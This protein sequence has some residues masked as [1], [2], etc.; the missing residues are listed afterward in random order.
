M[1]FQKSYI[2]YGG[3]WSTPFCRWQGS[4]AH[5]NSV[6]FAAEITTKALQERN[7]SP[8]VFN[9]LYLGI[10]VPQ[11]HTFY[12][13]PWL[14]GLIGAGTVTGSMIGQAC[15]TGARV[16]TLAG[17]DIEASA[18]AGEERVILTITTDRC[19]NGPHVYYPNPLGP[20]G[21]GDKEDWVWDNFGHDPFAKNAMIETAENVAKEA[22]ITKEEQDEM[23]LLRHRQYEDAL[24]DDSAFLR[25]YMVIPI[26]VKDARGRKILSTVEGDE[27]VF[28]TTAEGLAKLKPVLEGGTVPYGTQTYPADGTCGIIVTTREKARELSRDP[29]IEIQLLSYGEAR[30]KK[31]YMAQATVPATR[32]ALSRAGISIEDVKVIKT[33]NPFAVND[34]YFC[35]EMGVEPEAMNNY[36]S[37]LI[38]GHP[39]GPTG[40]RLIIEVIEEL[41]LAGGGHGL[42]VGCAAGDTSAAVVLK[43]TA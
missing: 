4:F 42:F 12:G 41:I 14:S 9:G 37:S 18:D 34:I 2:P 30:A 38:W 20:G 28:P 36:G 39:Q 15:A 7:I 35:R 21:T 24:K 27:G 29:E 5:L 8:Q 6:P 32:Q 25:R 11:M 31:G 17:F 23:T 1:F 33:H 43:V 3:Y 40:H 10:T 13:G 19:S 16:M 22:G 26:E